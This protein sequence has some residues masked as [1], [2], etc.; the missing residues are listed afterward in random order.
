MFKKLTLSCIGAAII[1]VLIVVGCSKKNPTTSPPPPPAAPTLV[2]PANGAT[3]VSTSPTLTWNASTGAVSYNLEVSTNSSFSSFVYQN[4]CL[5][6][7]SQAISGLDTATVYY[8]RVSA[9]NTNGT[10]GWSSV[11][12]FI[13]GKIFTPYAIG[14]YNVDR[15]VRDVALSGNYS[16]V[17]LGSSG[18]HIFDV[19]NPASPTWTGYY[20]APVYDRM[21][22]FFGVAVSG[23]YAYVTYNHNANYYDYG[24]RIIN[25]SNPASPTGVGL[26]NYN[27]QGW[28]GGVAVSGNYAYVAATQRGLQIYNVSNP[29]SPTLTG[30]YNT[31]YAR[32][33]AV[34]GSYAYVA[35]DVSGLR[36]INISNPASPTG[37]G[38]YDTP[39]LA[40]A[41]AVSGNYAYVADGNS[42]LRI[43]NISNPASPTEAG[44]YDTPGNAIGVAVSDNYAYVADSDSGLQIINISNPASPTGFYN[45]PGYVSGVTV[46][47]NYAH[48]AY[49]G[50]VTIIR[51]K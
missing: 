4:Y 16:Y 18:L 13:T 37:A 38:Y 28:L 48:V 34:S 7:D 43:I 33:V 11:W 23:N 50:F 20:V 45:M 40:M 24:L 10:S 32:D 35:D 44:Y 30:T 31:G 12:N 25:I 17:A 42:G 46:S 27:T 9:T 19:S 5:A 41:V 6:S 22:E 2:S 1:A 49:S 14:Y 15:Q 21:D 39:G 26:C 8:W 36:I 29:A 3:G 47:S 51:I